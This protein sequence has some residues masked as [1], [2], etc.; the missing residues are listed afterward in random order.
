MVKYRNSNIIN[1]N[2]VCK[3]VL[4]TRSKTD[5]CKWVED[6]SFADWFKNLFRK[7]K[8]LPTKYIKYHKN[9][10]DYYTTDIEEFEKERGDRFLLDKITQEFYEKPSV[11]LWYSSFSHGNE[12]RYFDTIAEAKQFFDKLQK[13][14]HDNKLCFIDFY[15]Q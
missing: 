9:G 5:W 15:A 11:T 14:A 3:I 6:I 8:V 2:Q 12:T 4:S 13:T 10:R 1:L 7:K